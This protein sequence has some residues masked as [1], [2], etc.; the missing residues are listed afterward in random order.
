MA[1]DRV[2]MSDVEKHMIF[3]LVMR[4]KCCGNPPKK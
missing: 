4:R 1:V 3:A 2:R